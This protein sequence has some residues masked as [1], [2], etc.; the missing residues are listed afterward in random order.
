MS[1]FLKIDFFIWLRFSLTHTQYYYHLFV[2]NR[3]YYHIL[4]IQVV[5]VLYVV[6]RLLFGFEHDWVLPIFGYEIQIVH[7][8]HTRY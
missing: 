6:V 5:V 4:E 3:D 2:I 8:N 7:P 1:V